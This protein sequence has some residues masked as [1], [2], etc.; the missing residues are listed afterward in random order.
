[1]AKTILIVDD[2]KFVRDTISKI[3]KSAH[4][5]VVGEASTGAEAIQSY[6]KLRPDVVTMDIVMPDMS[7]IE[8]TRTI[9]KKDPDAK[10]VILSAM[11][12]ENLVTEAILA[13]ARDFVV[14]PFE[15]EELLRTLEQV[16]YDKEHSHSMAR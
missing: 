13:G 4:Y 12:L 1:M 2:I 6:M 15:A 11:G 8:A 3:A 16:T 7:G 10:I 14:K 9:V 5:T